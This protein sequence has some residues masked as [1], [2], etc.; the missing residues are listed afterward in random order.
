M[1]KILYWLSRS[2]A[3]LAAVVLLGGSIFS[4]ISPP[5]IEMPTFLRAPVWYISLSLSAIIFL[6]PYRLD[7]GLFF[8][9]IRLAHCVLCSI[10]LVETAAE[11]IST[12]HVYSLDGLASLMMLLLAVGAPL[13]LI[14]YKKIAGPAVSTT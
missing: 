12:M 8:H 9:R 7:A 1:A 2:Y 13:S 4:V 14:L 11:D 5:D 6:L 3:Q 10:W